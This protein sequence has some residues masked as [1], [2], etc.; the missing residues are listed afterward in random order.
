[1]VPI[2]LGQEEIDEAWGLSEEENCARFGQK[3]HVRKY[4]KQGFIQR[5]KESGLYVTELNRNYFGGKKY[6]ENAINREAVLY[7]CSKQK[8]E[9]PIKGFLLHSGLAGTDKMIFLDLYRTNC[10]I[11]CYFDKVT[12][13]KGYIYIWGWFYFIGENSRNTKIKLLIENRQKEIKIIA[14]T[15]RIR[16]DIDNVFNED[17]N[18]RY[19]VSGI[20]FEM[21]S[22]F[23]DD[24]CRIFLLAKNKE[25]M[26]SMEIRQG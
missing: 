7:C 8:Y 24:G 15:F 2:D 10:E 12:L 22:S 5:I 17:K 19:L 20:S 13:R 21:E 3:D 23:C 25:K 18:G 9:N 6:R 16:E 26:A 1:M 14:L 11:N 4:S